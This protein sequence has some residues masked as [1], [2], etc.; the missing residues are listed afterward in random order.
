MPENSPYDTWP[1][2][3]DICNSKIIK[4]PSYIFLCGGPPAKD[5]D[6]IKSCRSLFY[7]FACDNN[8][9][10][11]DEIVLAEEVF[12]YFQHSSY[13]DLLSFE[14]DLA[15]LC[16]LTIVFSESA[17]SV[18]EIGAFSVLSPIKDKLLL[19]IHEK[20]SYKESFIWQG[21]AMHLKR[22]ADS[23]N[24]S[25]PIAVYR[26]KISK[27]DRDF[28]GPKDFQAASDLSETI[29]TALRSRPKSALID[30]E[31][32]GHI[33]LLI[34]GIL[35]IVQIAL[36]KDIYNL[37]SALG[38]VERKKSIE[39]MLSL[40]VSLGLVVQQPYSSQLF[41]IAPS[42][43]ERIQWSYAKDARRK[44]ST[45]WISIFNQHYKDF[46]K[47]KYLALKTFYSAE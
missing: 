36:L 3:I 42:E 18:A 10:Y 40:L 35:E 21:P 25:S 41:F 2:A 37:L 7:K 13:E 12:S 15:H 4:F 20:F 46:E 19:V 29:E 23:A 44:G 26:W 6:H 1:Q 33:M 22:F 17:G 34:L 43:N 9:F 24:R 11:F 28:L 8:C 27:N 16:A 31:D 30:P 45:P 38:V 47:R 5:E 32:R 14:Q 39:Q